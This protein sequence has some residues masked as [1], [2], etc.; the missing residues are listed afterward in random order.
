MSTYSGRI[1]KATGGLRPGFGSVSLGR[2]LRVYIPNKFPGGG[3][4][5]V[6]GPHPKN[7]YS[8]SSQHSM[9]PGSAKLQDPGS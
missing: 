8:P 5:V 1:I 9:V 2:A 4:V 3:L 7:H 6:L